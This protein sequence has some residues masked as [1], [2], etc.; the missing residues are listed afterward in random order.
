MFSDYELDKDVRKLME[1][2]FMGPLA[3][4]PSL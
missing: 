1:A 3:S 2:C 4:G